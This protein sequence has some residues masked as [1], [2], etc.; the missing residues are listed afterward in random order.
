[1]LLIPNRIYITRSLTLI[2]LFLTVPVSANAE[3]IHLNDGRVVEGKIIEKTAKYIKVDIDAGLGRMTYYFDEIKDIDGQP[4][5]AQEATNQ[6]GNTAEQIQQQPASQ[7]ESQPDLVNLAQ[8]LVIKN[9]PITDDQPSASND[10]SFDGRNWKLDFSGEGVGS[11]LEFIIDGETVYNW[12]GMI[13]YN[14]LSALAN[15]NTVKGYVDGFIKSISQ[16]CPGISSNIISQSDNEVIFE[17]SIVDCQGQQDQGEVDRVVATNDSVNI[18][19]YAAK[20]SVQNKQQWVE[21]FNKINLGDNS[22][23]NELVQ[24]SNA[25]RQ[26]N[27]DKAYSFIQK[28]D[29]ASAL[30]ILNK[31]IETDPNNYHGYWYRGYCFS[32]EGKYDDALKDYSKVLEINPVEGN[33]SY[34]AIADIY[35]AKGNYAKAD[36]QYSFYLKYFS[37]DGETYY[38]RAVVKYNEGS[39]ADSAKDLDKAS[40]LGIKDSEKLHEKLSQV[41]NTETIQQCTRTPTTP[42]PCYK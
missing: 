30:P 31:F 20:P 12:T 37:D 9:P 24:Q 15:G 6:N 19:H 8:N 14:K 39:Y 27:L 17:W 42:S 21:I 16:A 41:Q 3:T 22:K 32:S 35:F 13:T 40:S 25:E 18:L 36:E 28:N 34:K 33:K 29:C 2:F 11:I 23:L 38:A 26:G 10:L 7:T 1:M 5:T 4:F